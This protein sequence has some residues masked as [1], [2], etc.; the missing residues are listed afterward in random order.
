MLIQIEGDILQHHSLAR[1][2]Y[3][4]ASHLHRLGHKIQLK[5]RNLSDQLD[6]NDL[7]NIDDIYGMVGDDKPDVTFRLAFPPD[8]SLGN[9]VV[10]QIFWEYGSYPREWKYNLANSSHIVCGSQYLLDIVKNDEI[11]IDATLIHPG[12]DPLFLERK[13]HPHDRLR[14]LFVGGTTYRKGIDVLLDAIRKADVDAEFVIK[15]HPFYKNDISEKVNDLPVT[16]IKHYMSPS[17]LVD[18]YSSCDVLIYPTRAEG[19]G[20]PLLE[21]MAQGLT[22]ITCDHTGLSDFVQDDMLIISSTK[23]RM[24]NEYAS[25]HQPYI[26]EP[27]LDSLVDH[28][29]SVKVIEDRERYLNI[30]P[31]WE[32]QVKLYEEVFNKPLIPPRPLAQI[33]TVPTKTAITLDPDNPH[34]YLKLA[35]EEGGYESLKYLDKAA[36]LDEDNRAKILLAKGRSLL[37][38]TKQDRNKGIE[39][40]LEA[41]ELDPYFPLRI[42]K[43]PNFLRKRYNQILEQRAKVTGV[44]ICRNEE[45]NIER[46]L[47]SLRPYV[48]ELIVVD[49]GS[50][51]KTIELARKYADKIESRPDFFDQ[52]KGTLRSFAEARNRSLELA[53]CDYIFWMDADDE[54]TPQV[55]EVIRR[56]AVQDLGACAFKVRCPQ[57]DEKGHVSENTVIHYRM[58][59]NDP[60]IRFVGEI[61]EQV[62]PSIQAKGIEAAM[63]EA[64]IIHHGYTTYSQLEKKYK[65]NLTM[66][67]E[68]D[69][70]DDFS[71]YNIMATYM[72]LKDYEK[73]KEYGMS[74]LDSLQLDQA[75]A[76]KYLSTLTS[77]LIALED[78]DSA[79]EVATKGIDAKV[80]LPEHYF[81]LGKIYLDK[82]YKTGDKSLLRQSEKSYDN[83]IKSP[84]YCRG[85][86]IDPDTHGLKAYYNLGHVRLMLQDYDGA[87][88]AFLKVLAI[89]DDPDVRTALVDCYRQLGDTA[90]MHRHLA[91]LDNFEA[92]TAKAQE[93]FEQD[94]DQGLK[95]FHD[96]LL[97]NPNHPI[98]NL[99]YGVALLASDEESGT[100]YIEK[101]LKIQPTI[102]GYYNLSKFKEPWQAVVLLDQA[103][104]IDPSSGIL[105][106]E[107]AK[108]LY[109]LKKYRLALKALQ[110]AQL[111]KFD[112][113][114]L[115]ILASR[116]QFDSGNSNAGIELLRQAERF[117]DT[118]VYKDLW[119]K[120]WISQ[121]EG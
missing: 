117:M 118:S 91:L 60:D 77:V 97:A 10:H 35:Q 79:I 8:F 2:N 94:K 55:G 42:D 53:T 21:A 101:S 109:S 119:E 103:L 74:R 64:E 68:A 31:L 1:V 5:P 82:F 112:D 51:D 54:I 120:V 14:F 44:M 95:L 80:N 58:F 111:C 62:A 18:L 72:L 6:R 26:Y 102:Q 11:P 24:A 70:G 13:H 115:L 32:E 105:H 3:Q 15:D 9:K 29:R 108:N 33:L 19:L 61:H 50:T 88:E 34:L 85:G 98:A 28:I 96:V 81:N 23:K 41:A 69:N 83:A 93:V 52:D 92:K 17:E 16:Y 65:R 57:V 113:P 7:D 63:S 48:E 73:A 46:S 86:A 39:A 89:K 43:V 20:L 75:H 90:A 22:I 25:V 104:A 76:G 110:I 116:I 100:T 12:V 107:L 121:S 38:G 114:E 66:L 27:D 71:G 78:Y 84:A 30:I 37:T 99:N 36:E 56:V 47:S 59:K 49:T 67:L 87:R 4:L 40:I 106:Y 45:D